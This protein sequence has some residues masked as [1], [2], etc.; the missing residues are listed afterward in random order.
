M[1]KKQAVS[2]LVALVMLFSLVGT[3]AAQT[4]RPPAPVVTEGEVEEAIN[5]DHPIVLLLDTYFGPI[6]ETPVTDPTAV[7][8]DPTAPVVEPVDI[9]EQIA[10]YHADG[11]GFGV[12]VKLYAMVAES[13]EACSG[14]TDAACALK[15]EDLVT[16]FKSGT[17]IGA[18][19]KTYGRPS[20]MGV[21]HVKQKLNENKEQ[22]G[23][24]KPDKDNGKNGN[25]GN[26]NDKEDKENNGKGKK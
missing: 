6:L 8:T 1:H 9:G 25:N 26:G 3:A 7:P 10:T 13:K 15:I 18:L 5:Y 19:M 11:M 12:L 2:V 23:Q 17:G 4:E 24:G 20:M 22:H 21:G 14:S 16:Q